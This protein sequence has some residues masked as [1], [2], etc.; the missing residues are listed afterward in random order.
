MKIFDFLEFGFLCGLSTVEETFYYIYDHSPYIFGYDNFLKEEQNIV[1][2]LKKYNFAYTTT[3]E[4][5]KLALKISPIN[6][7]AALEIVNCCNGTNL[8]FSDENLDI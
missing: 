2:E 5:G 8:K 1:S 4:N 6:L 3:N 7:F